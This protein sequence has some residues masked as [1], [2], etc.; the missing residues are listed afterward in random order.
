MKADQFVLRF[1]PKFRAENVDRMRVKLGQCL[2]HQGVTG[3]AGHMIM[4][5]ADELICNIME[6]SHA[7]WVEV[8]LQ[9]RPESGQVVLLLRDDGVPF[10]P[11]E[12]NKQAL[13]KEGLKHGGDRHLGLY[14]V[15]RIATSWKYSRTNDGTVNELELVVDKRSPS[16]AKKPSRPKKPV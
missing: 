11:G 4:S 12:I 10:D 1:G 14:L 6:H 8:E 16:P 7:N 13:P 15:S 5:M 2:E 9:L 3:T